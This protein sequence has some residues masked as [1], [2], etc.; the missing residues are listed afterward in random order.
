SEEFLMCSVGDAPPSA[1]Q[2][3]LNN[4]LNLVRRFRLLENALKHRLVVQALVEPCAYEARER[5]FN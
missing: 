4:A 1:R 3:R 2:R 5:A